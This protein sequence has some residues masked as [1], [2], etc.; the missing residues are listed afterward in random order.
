ML[1]TT[2]LLLLLTTVLQIAAEWTHSE[3][4]R[5]AAMVGAVVSLVLLTPQVGW[6]RRSFVAIALGLTLWAGLVLPDWTTP[7]IRALGNTAF[8]AG[9]FIALATL[10]NAAAGSAAIVRCGLYLANQPPGR[11]YL[12][13]TFGGHLFALVLNY[14]SISLF[15]SLVERSVQS[16][17][18]PLIRRIR[19]RR[20]LL[21]IQRGFVTT[22]TWWPLTFAMVMSLA[23]V[24]GS[25]WEG[26]L[27]YCLVASFLLGA[28]GWVL[29][30]VFKPRNVVPPPRTPSP[31]GA[32]KSMLPLLGLLVLLITLVGTL[33]VVTGLKTVAVVML[34]VPLISLAWIARQKISPFPS[35]AAPPGFRGRIDAFV[36]RELPDYAP[37]LVLLMSAGYI[38]ILASSLLA[39]L[40]HGDLLG[41]RALSPLVLIGV[42]WFVP[43]AGQLGMNPILSVTLVGPLLP[44]AEQFGVSPDLVVL[45]L[46][47]GWALTG[48]SSPFT[49][50]NMLVGKFGGVSAHRA[51]LIWNGPYTLVAGLV[52]SAWLAFLVT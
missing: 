18:D 8:I 32:W 21:A 49:A 50:T 30:T 15:G 45:A 44:H 47:S 27:P 36:R 22:L 42:L 31:P 24:P 20:M 23:V 39:P 7:V 37:E 41:G 3:P 48:A 14:G 17:P 28:V 38:G 13:L 19:T 46:V 34:V 5:Q 51:G 40:V 4:L 12:A 35:G 11:R 1:Q 9:F 10:R 43:V 25:R 33:Q 52:L 2:G 26:A 29:D 16:E 6:A